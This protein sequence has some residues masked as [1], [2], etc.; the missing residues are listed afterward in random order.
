MIAS[1]GK[2]GEEGTV[3]VDERVFCSLRLV[4]ACVR[5]ACL[6]L[7]T[8]VYIV[9]CFNLLSRQLTLAIWQGAFRSSVSSL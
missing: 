9:S 1:A 2:A 7:S 5:R 8:Y 3:I 6:D 4:D